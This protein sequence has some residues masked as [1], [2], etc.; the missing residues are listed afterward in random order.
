M[1]KNALRGGLW[2]PRYS[3]NDASVVEKTQ[4]RRT[5]LGNA[6]LAFLTAEGRLLGFNG[7]DWAFL[8]GGFAL[9]GFVTLLTA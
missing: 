6:M 8:L 2:W 9:V 4:R 5:V 1:V 7:G 3:R